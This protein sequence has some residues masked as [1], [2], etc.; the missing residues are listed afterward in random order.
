MFVCLKVDHAGEP[1]D[2]HPSTGDAMKRLAA[3]LREER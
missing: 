3:R 1:A 2:F